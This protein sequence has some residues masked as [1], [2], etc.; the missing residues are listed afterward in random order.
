MSKEPPSVPS[1]PLA[2]R[3]GRR[4]FFLGRRGW[5][6][7]WPQRPFLFALAITY[8]IRLSR[9]YEYEDVHF[10]DGNAWWSGPLFVLRGQQMLLA[11]HSGGRGWPY[12]WPGRYALTQS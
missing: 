3:G 11:R 9:L 6:M 5:Q 2:Y 7:K 1:N 4:H 8:M 10:L 12:R